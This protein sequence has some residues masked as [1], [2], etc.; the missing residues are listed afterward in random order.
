[1]TIIQL[2]TSVLS[3]SIYLYLLYSGYRSRLIRHFPIFY[4]LVGWAVVRNVAGWALIYVWGYQSFLYYHF[5][6]ISGIV[7]IAF[8]I[9]LLVD[10]YFQIKR[11]N[12]K[13][14]WLLL[15]GFTSFMT[16]YV[17]HESITDLYLM[18]HTI[19]IYFQVLFCLLLHFQVQKN[20]EIHLGANYEGMLYGLSLMVALQSF[21]FGLRIFDFLPVDY[22]LQLS[23]PLSL[24]PWIIYLF[25]MRRLDLPRCLSREQLEEMELVRLSFR[26]AVRS[27]R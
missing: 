15:V 21:N 25:S 1:M 23:Q 3:Y 22:F 14:H 20:R 18:F 4:C 7:W 11:P 10:I 17:F 5:Y 24:I 12:Q 2:L 8:Q 27:V 9:Y 16:F 6:Y 19:C 26:K 13:G